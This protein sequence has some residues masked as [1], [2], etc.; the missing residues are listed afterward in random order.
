MKFMRDSYTTR[1]LSIISDENFA[2]EIALSRAP[3]WAGEGGSIAGC[4]RV[5][6]NETG[7]I[8]PSR[9]KGKEK[10]FN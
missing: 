10:N 5:S 6:I 9:G 4:D 2:T 7:A 8:R 3:G 1:A